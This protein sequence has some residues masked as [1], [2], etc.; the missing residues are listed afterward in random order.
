MHKNRVLWVAT[1]VLAIGI[2]GCSGK[3]AK[4]AEEEGANSV[5]VTV[6]KVG[7]AEVRTVL[8]YGA[9]L[10]PSASIR[11][12]SLI[13]DTI[14]SYPW[15]SGDEIAKG[16]IV[17]VMKTDGIKQ[18][19]AQIDAQV[20]ALDVQIA[21]LKSELARARDLQG[22]GVATQQA[23]DGLSAQ[24]EATVA[25]RQALLAGR[26][27]LAV[28][29][30]HAVV[31]APVDGVLSSKA[32]E[33]GDIATPQ[34][35][36][37]T[38]LVTDPLK[39]E[40]KL[41]EKDISMVK[42]GQSVELR[43]DAYPDRTFVGTVSRV[44]PYVEAATRTNTV[45]VTLPNP[46][47]EDGLRLMKPGMYGVAMLEVGS[48]ENVAVAPESALLLDNKLLAIQKEGENLRRA[49][50]VDADGVAHERT[51][52]LGSRQGSRW[53][54]LEGLTEGETIIV[55]GHHGLTD[56]DKVRVVEDTAGKDKKSQATVGANAGTGSAPDG[57]AP[58]P[59][60]E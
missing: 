21:N 60:A 43:L 6:E 19:L 24:Y 8:T 29:A 20:T 37:G 27:Q 52:K 13:T 55:R 11:L 22:K 2:A 34:L 30:G 45:E 14:L 35:P 44:F 48:R 39:M 56:G 51:V 47:G 4:K 18:G 25:Q 50:V 10:A 28:N 38:L 58:A 42:V 23:V 5:P 57:A 53:E 49:F 17:A 54:I 1:F 15:Q 26:R 36:L 7:I 31:K 59:A 40:L 41:V 16:Q 46:R 3:E 33:P 9:D 32:Y 12:L